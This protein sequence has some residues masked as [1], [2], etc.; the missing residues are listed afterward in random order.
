MRRLLVPALTAFTLVSCSPSD[1][2]AERAIENAAREEGQNADVDI[3][4]NTMTVTTDEGTVTLGGGV[5]ADWPSDIP[6]FADATVAFGGMQMPDGDGT[7]QGMMLTSKAPAASVIAFYKTALA[8]EGWDATN[9][10]VSAYG[11]AIEASKGDRKVIVGV[12]EQN[13]ETVITI[14][15]EASKQ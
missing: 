10:M 14:A 13:G 3:K 15:I 7:T 6:V 8:D 12:V 9:I 1:D 2:L 4:G 5:P 11:S